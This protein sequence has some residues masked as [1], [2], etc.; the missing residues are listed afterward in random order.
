[1]VRMRRAKLRVSRNIGLGQ[2]TEGRQACR[3]RQE[4]SVQSLAHR[5]RSARIGGATCSAKWDGGHPSND[6]LNAARICLPPFAWLPSTAL[7]RVGCSP[8]K[9]ADEPVRECN[10]AMPRQ[11]PIR[12]NRENFRKKEKLEVRDPAGIFST[13]P[14][15]PTS[16]RE[17]P[18]SSGSQNPSTSAFPVQCGSEP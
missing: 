5:W 3:R 13:R 12:R 6:L 11:K 16:G 14:D 1:M 7:S 8:L 18:G 9:I 17:Y 2:P 15:R 4:R 10:I